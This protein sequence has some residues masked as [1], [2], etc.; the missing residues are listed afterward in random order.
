MAKLDPRPYPVPSLP[1]GCDSAALTAAFQA[2]DA[3]YEKLQAASV[4]LPEG[5]VVG[6][7]LTFPVGDG[8]ACYLVVR[9]HPLTLQHV[10]VVDAYQI[11]SAHVRGI[12][13]REV[14]AQVESNKRYAAVL[15]KRAGR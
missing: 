6:A 5:E 9:A 2:H 13:R 3:I 11:P 7:F 12:T 14:L 8:R 15:A 4:A 1:F 10:P